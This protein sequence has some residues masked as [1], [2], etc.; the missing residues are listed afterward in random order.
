MKEVVRSIHEWV[1]QVKNLLRGKLEALTQRTKL[2]MVLAMFVLFTLCALYTTISA[3]YEFG[4]GSSENME[5]EHIR[6]LDLPY[7]Q[8]SINLNNIYDYGTE[9]ESYDLSER[10][11][12]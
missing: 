5:I 6:Q 3:F 12:S 1:E 8:D 7:K 9:Q 11:E 2:I 10:G 4:N